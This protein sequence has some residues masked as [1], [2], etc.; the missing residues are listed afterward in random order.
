MNTGIELIE[1][2]ETA[3]LEKGGEEGPILNIIGEGPEKVYLESLLK[4]K[5]LEKQII[6][7]GAIY[8]ETVI[9]EYFKEALICVSPDQAGLSVLK[10]MG[11]GVP[12]ITKK[13]AITGGEILNIENNKTGRLYQHRDELVKIL[14]EV[15]EFPQKYIEMGILAM[16][17]YKQN[18]SIS[19]MVQGFYDAISFVQIDNQWKN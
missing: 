6:L 16:E 11:Y 5:G 18:A 9:A 17:Y 19:Q 2:Y 13:D 3:F 1:A 14:Q 4:Q 10:S 8:D 15:A 7:R 12:F